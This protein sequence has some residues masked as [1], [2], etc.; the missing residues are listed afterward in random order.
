MKDYIIDAVTSGLHG[1]W[2][3]IDPEKAL[4][5][6]TPTNARKRPNGMSH[7]CWDL[8]HHMVIWQDAII[9][10]IK[11]ETVDWNAVEKKDNWPAAETLTNDSNFTVLVKKF[12]N[13]IKEA[14]ELLKTEN[15]TGSTVIGEDLPE[16]SVIKLYIILLQHMS[17]H[18]GQLVDVRKCLGDWPSNH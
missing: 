15:L 9:R 8:L 16:L 10:Q 2:T 13:G 14:K 11:G 12:H 17:Y 1:K 5:G 18:V 4:V 7:S 3:H 6:M